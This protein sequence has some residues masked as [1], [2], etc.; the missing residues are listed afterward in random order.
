MLWAVCLAPDTKEKMA[1]LDVMY[2]TTDPHQIFHLGTSIIAYIAHPSKN[3]AGNS[4]SGYNNI[5][6]G[7]QSIPAS[8]G[9]SL[10]GPERTFLTF[11][12]L[13]IVFQKYPQSQHKSHIPCTTPAMCQKQSHFQQGEGW[14]K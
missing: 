7:L 2:N 11:L 3:Q 4:L 13:S 9:S 10:E 5:I 6:I 14:N 12:A 1:A 8:N